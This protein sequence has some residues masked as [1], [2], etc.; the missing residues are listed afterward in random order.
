MALIFLLFTFPILRA[1]PLPGADS[2]VHETGLK[3][4]TSDERQ[5]QADLDGRNRLSQ[6]GLKCSYDKPIRIMPYN[7]IQ[8]HIAELGSF[9]TTHWK[10]YLH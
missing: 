3:P 6:E 2:Q 4:G 10:L 9:I 7:L 1:A 8:L 5:V